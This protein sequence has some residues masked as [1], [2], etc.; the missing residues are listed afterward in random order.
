MLSDV[1]FG[2]PLLSRDSS[3]ARIKL[4]IWNVNK[5]S[6]NRTEIKLYEHSQFF[7]YF[8]FTCRHCL[9]RL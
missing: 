2:V 4:L 3:Y 5:Q 1:C 8:H 6:Y 7:K 9:L